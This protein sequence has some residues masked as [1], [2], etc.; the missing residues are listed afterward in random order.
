MGNLFADFKRKR[1]AFLGRP[2]SLAKIMLLSIAHS[3]FNDD[4]TCRDNQYGEVI[5]CTAHVLF[6]LVSWPHR[7]DGELR[8]P[9]CRKRC[10]AK[11]CR[12]KECRAKERRVR[13]CLKWWSNEWRRKVY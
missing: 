13:D 2:L 3:G 1:L 4:D 8:Q 5:I 6:L 7:L 12:A 9:L 10:Q 11:E